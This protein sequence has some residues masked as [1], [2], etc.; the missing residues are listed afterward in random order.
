[1]VLKRISIGL[2]ALL[3][4]LSLTQPVWA[5]KGSGHGGS[6]SSGHSG[7]SNNSGSNSGSDDGNSN[8]G[9]GSRNS[10]GDDDDDDSDDQGKARRAASSG[11]AAPLREILKVVNRNY[12]GDVVDVKFKS[13]GK[14]GIYRIRILDRRGRMTEIKVD[15]ASR[16]IIP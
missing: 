7:G 1:M 6:G 13:K 15:A 10:G 9:K 16:Q 4:A 14:S 2:M 3:L 5:D 11:Q 12:E 8:S